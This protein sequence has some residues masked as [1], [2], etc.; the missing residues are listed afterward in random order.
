MRSRSV[1]STFADIFFP[2]FRMETNKFLHQ[3]TTLKVVKNDYFD[4]TRAKKVFVTSECVIFPYYDARNPK[5][6][7][8]A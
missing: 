1:I 5:L 2:H 7:N 3:L 4:T 6:H 8:G